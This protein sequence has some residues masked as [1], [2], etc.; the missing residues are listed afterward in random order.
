MKGRKIM[1]RIKTAIPE[2]WQEILENLSFQNKNNRCRKQAYICSPCRAETE[3]GVSVNMK[4]AR[5]YM[6]YAYT[7]MNMNASA[8]H[9]YLPIILC[10]K[11]PAERALAMKFCLNLL[12]TGG[13]VLVCGNRITSGMKDEI[14][15]AAQIGE[16][17]LVFNDLIYTEAQKIVTKVG[18][19]KKLVVLKQHPLMALSPEEISSMPEVP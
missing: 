12:E 15:H 10:D 13:T 14:L 19:D 4:A 7:E 9:A 2:N 5:L 11:I 6:Y 16:K 1:N 17:I 8:P 3:E 18:V